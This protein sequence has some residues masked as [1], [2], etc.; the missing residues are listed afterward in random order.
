MKTLQAPL[1]NQ[2]GEI[3]LS[4][5]MLFIGLMSVL[6]IMR[7]LDNSRNLSYRAVQ[8]ESR[9]QVLQNAK[10]YL[11]SDSILKYTLNTFNAPGTNTALRDCVLA[12]SPTVG[13]VCDNIDIDFYAQSS[14]STSERFLGSPS[15]PAYVN[16][17]SESCDPSA[18]GKCFFKCIAHCSFT[19]PDGQAACAATKIMKCDLEVSPVEGVTF[20]TFLL[21][22]EKSEYAAQV[23]IRINTAQTAY[24]IFRL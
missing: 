3:M 19:C 14:S 5:I 4:M 11:A 10:N 2:K 22:K 24:S 12:G 23:S 21:S 15:N 17:F 18:G 8:V 16:Q 13:G 7:T 6:M 9:K 1:K 20:K